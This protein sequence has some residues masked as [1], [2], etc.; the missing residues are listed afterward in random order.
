MRRS[1]VEPHATIMFSGET[2][3]LAA[4]AL[5]SAGLFVGYRPAGAAVAPRMPFIASIAALLGPTGFSL[6]CRRIGRPAASSIDSKRRSSVRSHLAE[7]SPAPPTPR[8]CTN[9]RRETDMVPPQSKSVAVS[10][11]S[12]RGFRNLTEADLRSRTGGRWRTA[13]HTAEHLDGFLHLRHRADGDA[14]MGLFHRREIAPDKD[15]KLLALLSESL[16]R[17]AD[18][19][20][21]EVRLRIRRLVAAL[22]EPVDREL[23]RRSIALLLLF[24]VRGIV[25]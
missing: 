11:W 10:G 15:A 16:R 14:G 13:Q 19:D 3:C 2:S 6:L 4:M 12:G 25:Q 8:V 23:A 1:S 24:E 22:F 18:V 9:A 7:M 21:D 5:T 20:E 17:S